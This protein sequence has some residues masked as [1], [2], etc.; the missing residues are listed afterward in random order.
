MCRLSSW[1]LLGLLGFGGGHEQ[2]LSSAHPDVK[3][4]GVG[5]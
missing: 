2:A 4:S 5:C 1:D 3:V